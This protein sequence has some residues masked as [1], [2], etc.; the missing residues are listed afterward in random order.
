MYPTFS[1]G[2]D[3]RAKDILGILDCLQA[4]RGKITSRVHSTLRTNRLGI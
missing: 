3:P 1:L 2:L 4:T